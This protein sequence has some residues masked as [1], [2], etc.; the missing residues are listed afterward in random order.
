MQFWSNSNLN[1][2]VLAVGYYTDAGLI[3]GSL[4]DLLLVYDG[5]TSECTLLKSA[6]ECSS[7]DEEG[8]QQEESV[9]FQFRR[10]KESTS[11][12]LAQFEVKLHEYAH[13]VLFSG[14]LMRDPKNRK[15]ELFEEMQEI[16]D[17][18]NVFRC[19]HDVPL[20]EWDTSIATTAQS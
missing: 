6:S 10:A 19:M 18:H 9:L 7:C 3:V 16:L 11:T 8:L 13:P 20:L 15:V 14:K 2:E 1:H 12:G 5:I 4:Q 17:L